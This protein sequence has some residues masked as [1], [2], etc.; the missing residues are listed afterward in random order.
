MA[1]RK[2][3]DPE[4]KKYRWSFTLSFKINEFLQSLEKGKR[5]EYVEKLIKND[6]RYQ[7]AQALSNLQ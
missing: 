1:G 5:T 6:E 2:P 3:K 4:D 7:K